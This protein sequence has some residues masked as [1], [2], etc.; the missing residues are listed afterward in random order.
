MHV[1]NAQP[2]LP[3]DWEV[4]PT[5]PVHSVPYYLAPLWDLRN[6]AK[7]K[8]SHSRKSSTAKKPARD[9][10][11]GRVPQELKAK[12]KRSKGAKTLL[13]ELEEEVRKFVRD[14]E[15]K[16]RMRLKNAESEEEPELDSE[17]EEIVFIGKNGTMS[18]EVRK[19]RELAEKFLEREK[20]IW[21]GAADDRGSGFGYV[22]LLPDT[23]M[24]GCYV[25]FDLR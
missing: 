2:P 11:K 24:A 18:D 25:M 13:Q 14:H 4:H 1:P 8:A 19:E 12:L 7:A 15:R 9:E 3:S 23:Q 16:E 22:I 6:E 10:Q 21:E 20:K 17:D 5:Y